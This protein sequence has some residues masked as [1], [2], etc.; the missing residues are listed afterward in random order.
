MGSELSGRLAVVTGAAA[1]IGAAIARALVAEGAD[2]AAIDIAPID[3]A[4]LH[5]LAPDRRARIR[6]WSCD[7]TRSADVGRVCAA[8]AAELGTVSI[9]VNN[10][11]GSGNARILEVED[12]TDEAWDQTLSLNLGSVM[13][14][15]R[16]FV[17]GMKAARWGRIVNLSSNTKDGVFR[18]G[19]TIGA[20]L[21][22]VAAKAA[23]VGLTKQLAKDLGPFDITC[24]AVAP[25]FTLPDPKAR[26]TQRYNA[27]PSEE[28]AALTARVPLGRPGSGDDIANAV[29]FL[30]GPRSGYISGEVLIVAGGV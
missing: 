2:L 11:G 15:C 21:P 9:L 10:V 23:I 7:A 27:L 25:G 17:P 19:G 28:Q 16:A 18:T 20:R 29:C 5:A 13:R 12:M 8:I 4:A 1:G 3:I 30:A 14:F 6:A 24:N 22:Y 26:I